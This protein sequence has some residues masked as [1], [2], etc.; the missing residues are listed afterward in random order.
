MRLDPY[1]ITIQK[2]LNKDEETRLS[3]ETP[4]HLKRLTV[5]TKIVRVHPSTIG[6]NRWGTPVLFFPVEDTSTGWRPSGPRRIR[7]IS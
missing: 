3:S 6:S 2:E 7:P 1:Y 5:R 4:T